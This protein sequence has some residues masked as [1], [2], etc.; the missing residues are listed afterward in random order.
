MKRVKTRAGLRKVGSLLKLKGENFWRRVNSD[1]T[2]T[3]VNFQKVLPKK[4]QNGS[5]WS[6]WL[7]K[8]SDKLPGNFILNKVGDWLGINERYQNFLLR[9]T[10]G[11]GDGWDLL[12][13]ATAPFRNNYYDGKL[14]DNQ[15]GKQ[16]GLMNA[17]TVYTNNFKD[18]NRNL[19]NLYTQKNSKGFKPS[20]IGA[21]IYKDHPEYSKYPAWEGNFYN[22]DT[23][24]L[25]LKNKKFFDS[26]LNKSSVQ[27]HDEIIKGLPSVEGLDDVRHYQA[28]PRK[29]G[30]Q[31]YIDMEDVWNLDRAGF[32][33]RNYPF[34]LNQ[35]IPVVFDDNKV[36]NVP[37]LVKLWQ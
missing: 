7:F 28:T 19:V 29:F 5:H 27:D 10:E 3:R 4:G 30:N 25:P 24:Y 1:G 9:N 6:N 37:N 20:K 36:P 11:S 16:N 21:G 23:L 26:N 35:R 22:V 33:A 31:Y 34:I 14:H 18:D 17:S 8:F 2:L 15:K 13:I 12:S 32:D